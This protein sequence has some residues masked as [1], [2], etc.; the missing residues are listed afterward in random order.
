MD[1]KE[2]WRPVPDYEAVYEKRGDARCQMRDAVFY[3]EEM[4]QETR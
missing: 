1:E 4:G 2:I 3:A